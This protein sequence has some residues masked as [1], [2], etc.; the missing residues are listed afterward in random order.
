LTTALSYLGGPSVYTIGPVVANDLECAGHQFDASNNLKDGWACLAGV[1][2]DTLGNRQV[3]RPLRI[4][5]MATLSSTACSDFKSLAGIVLSDPIEIQTSVPLVV[6]TTPLVA[7]DEVIVSGVLGVSGIN[8]RW[9]VTP[10]DSSGKR[11][12][13]QGA[14]PIEGSASVLPTGRVVPVAAMP[15]CTGTVIKARTDAGV[16]VVDSTKHCKQWSNFVA[17]QLRP[18]SSDY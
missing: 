4:C 7:N 10:L 13:L 12:A 5:V 16:A 8:S 11:F 1:A 18:Y 6:G 15:D 14:K 3:S 9:K 17:G 2:N